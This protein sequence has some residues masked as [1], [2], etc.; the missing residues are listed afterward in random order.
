MI[1]AHELETHIDRLAEQALV[2]EEE[3]DHWTAWQPALA[4]Y[5]LSDDFSLLTELERDTLLFGATAL[6]SLARVKE[7]AAEEI[8]EDV[9]GELDEANW[10]A[11]EE[12]SGRKLSDKMDVWFEGYPE[13]E[14]L[15]FIEDLCIDDEEEDL[16]PVGSEM[17]V[18]ALKTVADAL[19]LKQ[20][21]S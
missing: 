20:N 13:T 17:M 9:I 2:F 5:I 18:V 8:S 10:T 21:E 3:V 15:A 16:T 14:L 12:A 6:L 7:I 11:I 4:S 1:E 19:F